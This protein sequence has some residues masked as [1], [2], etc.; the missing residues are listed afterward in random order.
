LL[1]VANIL[2]SQQINGKIVADT[3]NITVIKIWGTHYE[4][5]YAYGYLAGE[6]MADIFKNY[7]EPSY[8]S[9]LTTAKQWIEDGTN[10]SIP[11]EYQTEAIGM[12]D[13]MNDAGINTDEL[14]YL[15]VLASNVILDFYG[16]SS[17]NEV[18]D[19]GCSAFMSWGDATIGTDIEGKSVISRHV[20]W[21][22]N[23]S[24]I[25]NQVVVAHIPEEDD[26]QPWIMIGFTGQICAL[27][28]VSSSGLAVFMHSLSDASGVATEGR[29]Y[30]PIWFSLR[31]ALEQKDYNNDLQDD[32]D[33]LRSI[34]LENEYGYPKESIITCI[35]SS[36][37][38]EDSL[39]ALVAELAC[40]EP[41]HS[42]RSN[43]YEDLISGDNLYAANNSIVRNDAHNYCSR[44]NSVVANMGDG[45]LIGDDENWGILRDYSHSSTNMQFMQFIPDDKILKV[46]VTE[47]GTL[48]YQKEPVVFIIDSL[49]DLSDTLSNFVNIQDFEVNI[50]P[51]PVNDILKIEFNSKTSNVDIK[52]YNIAGQL[53]YDSYFEN[54]NSAI[55]DVSSFEK[56]VYIIHLTENKQ[57]LCRKFVK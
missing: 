46:S 53:L 8:G 39:I 51:N 22:Q 31:K 9:Y 28:G 13:G 21:T 47:T 24:L 55:V 33:D 29:A 32:A 56:G 34:L 54:E 45:T 6:G 57:T 11:E 7:I 27:S 17:K 41:Y 2:F 18:V 1:F 49:F 50:S 42:F 36:A 25:R 14:D 10:I 15:D 16:F 48:A 26:E 40:V 35:S 19:I 5:G 44:Y 38:I 23:A 3:S 4:R 43:S 20:D 30:E 12:I 37:N 52:I